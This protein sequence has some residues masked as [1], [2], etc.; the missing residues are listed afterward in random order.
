[1]CHALAGPGPWILPEHMSPHVPQSQPIAAGAETTANHRWQH[2]GWI[3]LPSSHSA[4][5]S[6]R[7]SSPV[8]GEQSNINVLKISFNQILEYFGI[9]QQIKRRSLK[10]LTYAKVL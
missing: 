3:P 2:L 4:P 6:T 9:F 10:S 5:A 1:M 8:P 7:G